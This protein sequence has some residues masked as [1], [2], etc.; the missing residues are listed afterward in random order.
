MNDARVQNSFWYL[1]TI[2]AKSAT[3]LHCPDATRIVAVLNVDETGDYDLS[4][5]LVSLN[6]QSRAIEYSW[7]LFQNVNLAANAIDCVGRAVAIGTESSFI[8][9]DIETGDLLVEQRSPSWV[10]FARFHGERI[11]TGS[12][13]GSFIVWELV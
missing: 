8:I 9:V 3:L 11:L 4:P 12:S 13:N 7:P 10:N 6:L 1:I 5:R 2:S